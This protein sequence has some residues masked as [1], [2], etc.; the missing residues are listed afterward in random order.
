VLDAAE[1]SRGY[2]HDLV[3][4]DQLVEAS[5]QRLLEAMRAQAR[6]VNPK[7]LGILGKAHLLAVLSTARHD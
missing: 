6:P 4:D 5:V 2:L 3:Q 7:K 1:L